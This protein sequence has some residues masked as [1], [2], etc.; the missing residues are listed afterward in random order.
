MQTVLASTYRQEGNSFYVGN[1]LAGWLTQNSRGKPIFVSVRR[2]T[3][4][5][6]R[7]FNGWGISAD[8]L[9]CLKTLDV[10]FVVLNVDG[11][12]TLTASPDTWLRFRIPYQ[13]APFEPQLI[14]PEQVMKKQ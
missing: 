3:K 2:R 4:H 11:C 5:H 8:L 10:A 9:K 6:F 7:I 1:R 13:R 14:I 12:E